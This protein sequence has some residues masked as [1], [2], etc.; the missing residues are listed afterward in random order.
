[1]HR[2]DPEI[3][4]D[5][6]SRE[7]LIR[8]VQKRW[9]VFKASDYKKGDEKEWA[10]SMEG[11]TIQ[12]CMQHLKFLTP[13]RT[14][15]VSISYTIHGWWQCCFVRTCRYKPG[16]TR[17]VIIEHGDTIELA[18]LKVMLRASVNCEANDLS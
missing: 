7:D 13:K 18:I 15:N 11:S 17:A 6:A 14:G 2:E 10:F 8:A 5:T 1:M 9:G 4:L 12:I 3:D 16:T